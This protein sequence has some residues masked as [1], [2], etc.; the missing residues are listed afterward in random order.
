M[1]KILRSHRFYVPL[2]TIAGSI[3]LFLVYHFFYV[4]SQRSYADERAFR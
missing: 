1:L 4:A 2:I 3:G